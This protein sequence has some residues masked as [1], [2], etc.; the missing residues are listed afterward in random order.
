MVHLQRLM[1]LFSWHIM[2]SWPPCSE[3]AWVCALLTPLQG[4]FSFVVHPITQR[5]PLPHKMAS[6]IMFRC[7]IISMWTF[8]IQPNF[9]STCWQCQPSLRNLYSG[10][11]PSRGLRS[12]QNSTQLPGPGPLLSNWRK[13]WIGVR[14]SEQ[15]RLMALLQAHLLP[16]FLR[17]LKIRCCVCMRRC[18]SLSI[19]WTKHSLLWLGFCQHELFQDF[20]LLSCYTFDLWIEVDL[21]L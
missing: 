8:N 19:R 7:W 21:Q 5:N 6:L 10:S 13:S 11:H 9:L 3:A 17:D 2:L 12:D 1:S 20:S 16:L 4:L 15:V 18:R 14:H